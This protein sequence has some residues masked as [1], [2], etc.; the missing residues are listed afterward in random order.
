MRWKT[1]LSSSRRKNSSKGKG[2]SESSSSKRDVD[3]GVVQSVA[4]VSGGTSGPSAHNLGAVRVG[5]LRPE[6]APVCTPTP[7]AKRQLISELLEPDDGGGESDSHGVSASPALRSIIS[8]KS[9][10]GK[11]FDKEVGRG[12]SF[13]SYTPEEKVKRRYA[14][15]QGDKDPHLNFSHLRSTERYA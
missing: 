6:S 1:G 7:R 3:K 10:S 9:S 15:T 5:I 12:D 14:L 11:N 13:T 8:N 2:G 4:A